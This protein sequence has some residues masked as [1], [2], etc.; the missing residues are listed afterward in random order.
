MFIHPTPVENTCEASLDSPSSNFLDIS[1]YILCISYAYLKYI[2]CVSYVYMWIYI[3]KW[4]EMVIRCP[5]TIQNLRY[6]YIYYTHPQI[7]NAGVIMMIM[8]H[9]STSHP[10]GTPTWSPCHWTDQAFLH[11]NPTWRKRADNLAWE[12]RGNSILPKHWWPVVPGVSVSG[13]GPSF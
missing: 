10:T 11:G 1:M 12:F 3:Y 2:L 7:L 4:I 9:I 13:D 8:A 5:R 6:I